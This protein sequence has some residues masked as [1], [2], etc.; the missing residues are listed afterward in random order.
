MGKE[1]L[2]FGN[3]ETEKNKI[4][5]HKTLVS[6]RDVYIEKVLVSNEISFADKSYNHFIGYSYNDHKV[7]PIHIILPKTSAYVKS[8]DGQTKWMYFLIEDDDLLEK[9]NTF[10][11]KVS[12][13]IKKDFDNEPVYNEEYLKTKIKYHGD[14]FTDFY[15]KEIPKVNFNHTCLTV[16]TLDF[17][18]KKDE[19]YYPQIFLKECKYIMKKVIGHILSIFSFDDD[20]SD[21][22]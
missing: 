22:E 18:P 20:E 9:Y 14:E 15:D 7:K 16:I 4:C 2:T 5:H 19:S 17:V 12:A 6:L 11:D 21:E 3:I 13:D 1:I 10:W 8:F